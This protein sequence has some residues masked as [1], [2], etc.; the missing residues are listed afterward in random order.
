[1]K[2]R[3]GA[4]QVEFE[5]L[6]AR[7]P[8]DWFGIYF[9]AGDDPFLGSHLSYVRQNGMMEIAVYPGPRVIAKSRALSDNGQ[10]ISGRHSLLIQFENNELEMR[11]DNN[12]SL[13]TD[14]LSHQTAGLVMP[15][16][17]FADVDV[18]S[19][20]MICR[21]TIEWDSLR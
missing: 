1:V 7:R 21:D 3:D 16:A 4:V 13:R 2:T 20:E 19:L 12:C 18:H 11:I 10:T 14:K 8:D 15:A 6:T 17:Y 9:R 5:I